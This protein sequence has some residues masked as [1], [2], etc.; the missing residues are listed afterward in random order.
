MIFPDPPCGYRVAER[1]KFLEPKADESADWFKILNVQGHDR[2]PNITARQGDER[3]IDQADFL[4]LK[5][6][7]AQ[8]DLDD[9][10]SCVFPILIAWID[11]PPDPFEGRQKVLHPSHS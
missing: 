9:E 7:L 6:W 8:S 5:V 4:A 2:C 11:D 10:Q 3:V 1:L